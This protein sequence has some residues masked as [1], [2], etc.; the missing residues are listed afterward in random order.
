MFENASDVIRILKERK[1]TEYDSVIF[2]GCADLGLEIAVFDID[3]RC[4][5]Y[6]W[7]DTKRLLAELRGCNTEQADIRE[8]EHIEADVVTLFD[9]LE[10]VTKE[11]A[12]EILKRIKCKQLLMWIPVQDEY[13]DD[14]D[15]LKKKQEAHKTENQQLMQHLSLWTPDELKE[16]GFDVMY[17]EGYH[18]DRHN[19]WG[20]CIA[21][22]E[23]DERNYIL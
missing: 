21:I 19:N 8:L 18:G 6:E 16:L 20:A 15:A 1:R 10:H 5:G 13:R 14:L 3:E 23:S 2:L 22:K 11:E 12:I 4:L 17:K 7:C 9:V